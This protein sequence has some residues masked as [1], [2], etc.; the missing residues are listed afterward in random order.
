MTE[1]NEFDLA[2]VNEPSM[3]ELWRFDCRPI[4]YFYN[5]KRANWAVANELKLSST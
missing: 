4:L 3:F 2:M 1:E 5:C